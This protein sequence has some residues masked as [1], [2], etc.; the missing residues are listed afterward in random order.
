MTP[1]G[2]DQGMWYAEDT[3]GGAA[4]TA[5]ARPPPLRQA[6][7]SEGDGRSSATNTQEAGVDEGDLVETDGRY[8]YAVENGTLH[9]VDATAGTARRPPR[10][11][12]SRATSCSSTATD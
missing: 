10:P 1:W 4:T 9:V 8:V 2:F 3:A 5:A 7:A 12:S 6:P 11:R